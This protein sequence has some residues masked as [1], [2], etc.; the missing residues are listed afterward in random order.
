MSTVKLKRS[1]EIARQ[2]VLRI[3][4]GEYMVGQKL[5]T[6]PQLSEAYDVGRS[7]V[8]EAIKILSAEGIVRVRQG[9][10]TF[11]NSVNDIR[12]DPLGIV[13]L[14]SYDMLKQKLEARLLLEPQIALAAV[15][16]ATKE[17]I[18]K[19]EQLC[20]M[21]NSINGYGEDM[22]ELD[23]E[24]HKT[25]AKCTHNEVLVRI[26]PLICDAVRDSETYMYDSKLS[27]TKARKAHQRIV[28]AL[29]NRD[30]I[31]VRYY[32]EQHI[33]ETIQLMSAKE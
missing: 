31:N 28:E 21:Y 22:L 3:K 19:L 4:D 33:Q 27:H 18:A 13:K 15:R 7:T 23:I 12:E 20:E 8:R 10:G 14:D 17:D 9:S 1:E 6:E 26:I 30:A 2:I 32:M 25:V 16:K 29:K 5:P 11:V 24:F